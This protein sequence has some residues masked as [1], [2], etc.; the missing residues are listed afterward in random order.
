MDNDKSERPERR[1][2]FVAHPLRRMDVEIAALQEIRLADEGQL[3]ENGG[4]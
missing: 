2:A 1:T 3:T 4:G